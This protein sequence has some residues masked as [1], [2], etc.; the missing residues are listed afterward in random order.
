MSDIEQRIRDRAYQL[1][2]QA[3]RPHGRGEEFWF[4]AR[5][6]IADDTQDAAPCGETAGSTPAMT[7]Q[8]S[9]HPVRAARAAGARAARKS[10]AT[11]EVPQ[12]APPR[13]SEAKRVT[14]RPKKR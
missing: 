9:A 7:P 6:E 12:T 4:A 1:W 13:E 8:Q 14:K 10:A 11:D 5:R 3:G 2:E